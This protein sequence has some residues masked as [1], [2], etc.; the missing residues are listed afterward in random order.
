[1]AH[2]IKNRF[3]EKGMNPPT[4]L[5]DASWRDSYT[6]HAPPNP[7]LPMFAIDINNFCR[8]IRNKQS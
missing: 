8:S 6:M 1:M 5:W 4:V 3:K 2:G 7:R